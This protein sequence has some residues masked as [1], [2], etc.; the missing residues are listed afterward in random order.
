MIRAVIFDF[1][2]TL[3]DSRAGATECVNYALRALGL[4]EAAPVAIHRTVGLSLPRTF[5]ILTGIRD[6]QKVDEFRRL[7]AARADQVMIELTTVYPEVRS[8]LANL[9]AAEMRMAVVSTKFRYR[10]E[11]ILGRDGLL[12]EFDVIV[13]GE[14][15][16]N[17]KPD[18]EGL[19]LAIAELALPAPLVAYV[20]DHPVDAEA[21]ERAH[22][23]FIAMLTGPSTREEFA[24]FRVEKFLESLRQLPG[25]LATLSAAS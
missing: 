23:R 21:A 19:L 16:A 1:D 9:R 12:N 24:P 11:G 25:A 13:G 5:E 10:I 8:V 4:P 7:F 6:R 18:P 14:D 17:H 3:A 22:L 15:V 2:L 20:G